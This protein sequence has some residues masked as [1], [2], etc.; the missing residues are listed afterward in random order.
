MS[1][2]MVE[3]EMESRGLPSRFACSVIM[4]KSLAYSGPWSPYL[5]NEKFS[6]VSWHSSLMACGSVALGQLEASRFDLFSV[7][8]P[9]T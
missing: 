7:N 5:Q 2:S 4:D 8:M 6:P 1:A 9:R 3:R